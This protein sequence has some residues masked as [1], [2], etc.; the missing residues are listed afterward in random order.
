[1]DEIEAD[2]DAFIVKK[3]FYNV[4]A[5]FCR[6]HKL[7]AVTETTFFKNLPQHIPLN[8]YRPNIQH[9]RAYCVKGIRY[10]PFPSRTSTVSKV[11]YSLS[12]RRIEYQ[13]EYQ[14][15]TVSEPDFIKV[16][17][18][19]DVQDTLDTQRLDADVKPNHSDITILE[20]VEAYMKEHDSVGCMRA[21]QELDIP[22]PTVRSIVASSDK[23]VYGSEQQTVQWK[24]RTTSNARAYQGTQYPNSGNPIVK[25]NRGQGEN[26]CN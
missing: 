2:S 6:Q 5:D 14:I 18:S 4:F 7:P 12:S 16:Q 24:S 3:E 25:S 22:L 26:T 21:S 23:L 17:V 11:F 1:M 20:R 9:K 8:N 15:S 13:N 10:R 19:L